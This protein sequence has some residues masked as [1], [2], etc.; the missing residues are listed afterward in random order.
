MSDKTSLNARVGRLF[1]QA[2][3]DAAGYPNGMAYWGEL[4]ASEKYFNAA[5]GLSFLNY[6]IQDGFITLAKDIGLREPTL[7]EDCDALMKH[8]EDNL[9]KDRELMMARIKSIQASCPI[10]GDSD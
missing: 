2:M 4:P 9:E 6:L 5:T 1:Y 3:T 8:F 7:R 10:D